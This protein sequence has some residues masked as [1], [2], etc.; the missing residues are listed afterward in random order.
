MERN[1]NFTKEKADF[2]FNR[3]QSYYNKNAY[4]QTLYEINNNRELLGSVLNMGGQL[5]LNKIFSQSLVNVLLDYFEVDGDLNNFSKLFIE[6]KTFIELH[7]DK[8]TFELLSQ[9]NIQRESNPNFKS[10]EIYLNKNIEADNSEYEDDNIQIS[11]RQISK[12]KKSKDIEEDFLNSIEKPSFH[13]SLDDSQDSNGEVVLK[14][15]VDKKAIHDDFFDSIRP[16]KVSSQKLNSSYQQIS[17]DEIFGTNSSEEKNAITKERDVDNSI[18]SLRKQI[19]EIDSRIDPSISNP[20][21][22][23]KK[24]FFENGYKTTQT[25]HKSGGKITELT[26]DND[27]KYSDDNLKQNKKSKHRP[28]Q[29]N[30]SNNNQQHQSSN[31]R[32]ENVQ[33]AKNKRETKRNSNK[34]SLDIQKVAFIILLLVF[35][36][37]SWKFIGALK[38]S[39]NSASNEV[40]TESTQKE[41]QANQNVNDDSSETNQTQPAEEVKPKYILPSDER[42][43]TEEDMAKLTKA[44][45]RLAINELFARH[46]WHFGQRGSVYE[47]FSKQEW[48][49]PD[50]NM[51]SSV[52]AENKFSPLERKNLNILLTKFKQL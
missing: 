24:E 9:Y 1:P 19:F 16:P 41:N 15:N 39:S 31:L 18:D 35:L 5:K 20:N 13:I 14:S 4:V 42:E 22:V 7:T 48:Y 45:M 49:K 10:K 34:N 11:I 17:F 43:I 21:V 8:Q 37:I 28:K 40:T 50:L 12:T 23:E 51:Q 52:G 27:V 2:I 36:L 6:N 33:K 3:I 26:I 29:K 38:S 44:E 47:Y 30:I 46:G 25:I 32:K